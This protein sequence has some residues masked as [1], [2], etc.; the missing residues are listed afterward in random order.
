MGL[1]ACSDDTTGLPDGGGVDSGALACANDDACPADQHCQGGLCVPGTGNACVDDEGCPAGNRCEVVTGCGATRCH[2]NTCVPITTCTSTTD[3]R[4]Y[5]CVGG[6]CT[7]PIP[8]GADGSCPD[9]RTC[10]RAT[11]TCQPMMTTTSTCTGDDDCDNDGVICVAGMCEQGVAC[12]TSAECPADRRCIGDFCRPPCTRDEDCG[13]PRFRCDVPTGECQARCFGDNTCPDQQIC[14]MNLCVPEQCGSTP[15]CGAPD[16]RCVGADRGH[17]RCESFVACDPQNPMCP[18]N[19]TCNAQGE[20]EALP[21]CVGDR[22]CGPSEFCDDG[23]CQPAVGC[24][25]MT[26]PAGFDCVAE[27]CVPGPC[28]GLADCP[29][30][31]EIC[32]AGSCVMPPAPSFVTEVRILTPSGVVRPGTSYTFVAI[33]LDQAGEVVSGVTFQWAS[34]ST[35]VATIAPSGVATGGVR[36]GTTDITASV[37]VPGQGLITSPPVRLVN[38]GALAADAVRVTVLSQSSSGVVVGAPVEVS[39]GG[40]RLGRVLTDASGI[41]VVRGVDAAAVVDVT[42]ADSGHDWVSVVGAT[43]HDLVITLPALTRPDRAGGL[44]GPIDLSGVSS[45][46][47]LGYSV[48]GASF[49][50]PLVGTDASAL[51]GGELFRVRLPIGNQTVPVPSAST[52]SFDFMGTP[53]TLKD[54]YYARARSGL[55]AAWSFGG[56]LDINLMGGGGGNPGDILGAALPYFQQ[57][58]HAV[59]PAFRVVEIPT[60]ADTTDVD[61]DGDSSELTTDWARLPTIPLR[62][63]VPQSLRFQMVVDNAR[64]PFLADGNANAIV[65]MSGVMLP[66]VGFV[67]LGLDGLQDNNGSGVV[68]SFTTRIAPAHGGLEVGEYAVVALAIRVRQNGLPG[69]GSARIATSSTLPTAVDFTDGWIDAPRAAELDRAQRRLTALPGTGADLV[70]MTARSPEGSWEVW[71]PAGSSGWTF[72]ATPEGATDRVASGAEFVLDAIDLAPGVAAGALFD[73]SR[74]GALGVDRVTR[75]YARAPV[76]VR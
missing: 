51:F 74:G 39:V 50:S 14:E 40:Q 70:R 32:L 55:R 60:A 28:R 53:I 34:T 33:A 43:A 46:G 12:Q 44:K 58:S 26:C 23:H 13:G 4:G 73:A 35:Q 61:G 76:S 15:D 5:D 41:A 1:A 54:T 25:A 67:P 16:R 59:R 56:K 17:G 36:A 2:G 30:P 48:T 45:T 19:T 63:V 66:G 10:D 11:N 49:P 31:G 47:A 3:C 7:A 38:I 6:T 69:P 18:A 27:R 64:L 9:G 29:N 72:P 65:V 8:C 20:C 57:F 71:V 24:S 62:P 22:N 42:V 75:G 21:T 52:L 68:P 37:N